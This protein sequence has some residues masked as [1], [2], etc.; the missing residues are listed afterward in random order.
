MASKKEKLEWITIDEVYNAF[1]DC[2]VHKRTSEACA[3]FESNEA[4]NIYS[5]W[6]DLNTGKYEIGYSDTFIVTRPKLR[7]VF[8]ADFRDRIV[9]HLLMIKTLNLFENYF[10]DNTFNCRVGKGTTAAHKVL[11]DYSIQYADGWVL[12][13]DI[14]GFFMSIPK[15]ELARRLYNFLNENYTGKDKQQIIDLTVKVVMHCPEKKCIRKGDVSLW[16]QLESEKS[17]FT[18]GENLGMAIGNLTSQI[19]ANFY[20]TEF[21]RWISSIPGVGYCRYVDDFR[22]FAKDKKTLLK[23]IPKIRKRLQEHDKL[24]LHK[25]KIELQPVKN[26]VSFVGCCVKKDRMYIS[27]RTVGNCINMINRFNRIPEKILIHK[28]LIDN[29]I[30]SYNSYTGFLKHKKTFTIRHKLWGRVSLIIKRHVYITKNYL[31]VR[32]KDKSKEYI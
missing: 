32:K 7:E 16:D 23:L 4:A 2:R 9:H 12:S 28:N 15:D 25:K 6:S 3:I 11:L 31:V 14:R 10:I 22:V 26:G 29:F 8:A 24:E 17:L 19:Y 1:L 27:N 20:L 30:N 13:C 18:C 21:D 5:L